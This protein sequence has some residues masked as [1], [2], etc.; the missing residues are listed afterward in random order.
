MV[1]RQEVCVFTFHYYYFIT[2]I[3]IVDNGT[4]WNMLSLN[5]QPEISHNRSV[6]WLIPEVWY[7]I[8]ST[9]FGLLH[10]LVQL[11]GPNPCLF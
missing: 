11:R 10:P 6:K 4:Y 3:C 1:K 5:P 7:Q 9:V 8:L 2:C